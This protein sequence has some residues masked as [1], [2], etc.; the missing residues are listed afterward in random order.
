MSNIGNSN[1]SYFLQSLLGSSLSGQ[2]AVWDKGR[3]IPNFD[4]SVWRWDCYGAVMKRSDYG[5]CTS[6]YGW[7]IDHIY[8]KEHG[9]SEA[10]SNKQPLQWE[11]NRKKGDRLPINLLGNLL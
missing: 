11:N 6:K 8:P 7:E 3:V 10:L 5:N 9:G 2:S 1:E 4:S